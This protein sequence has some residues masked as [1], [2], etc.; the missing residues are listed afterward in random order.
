MGEDLVVENMWNAK[1]SIDFK[2]TW[3]NVVFC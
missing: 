3:N 1:Y 2:N